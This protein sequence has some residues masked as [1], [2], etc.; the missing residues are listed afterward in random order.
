[1]NSVSWAQG[2]GV[3]SCP[4]GTMIFLDK[5]EFSFEY[6]SFY[7]DEALMKKVVDDTDYGLSQSEQDEIAAWLEAQLE[8]PILVNGVDAAGNYLEGVPMS[9]IVKT[10][11]IPPPSPTGWR[12]DFTAGEGDHW[13]QLH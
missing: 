3:I 1:M 12:Y 6:D 5:P 8:L 4:A 10:V 2:R 7:Y 9:A 13:V 11:T